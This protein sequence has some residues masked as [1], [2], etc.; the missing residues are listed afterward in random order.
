MHDQ[1]ATYQTAV[2]NLKA[3]P[4]SHSDRLIVDLWTTSKS[5]FNE[6][7]KLTQ[8]ISDVRKQNAVLSSRVDMLETKKSLA[9]EALCNVPMSGDAWL[10]SLGTAIAQQAQE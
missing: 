10:K 5:L 7:V 4:S 2:R 6:N 9:T 3:N 1:F 8:D